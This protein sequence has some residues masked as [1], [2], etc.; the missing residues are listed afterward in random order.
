MQGNDVE[1]MSIDGIGFRGDL[2]DQW[3]DPEGLDLEVI[4]PPTEPTPRL[5]FPPEA[6]LRRT[7]LPS[8]IDLSSRPD[9]GDPGA[10]CQRHRL[11]I[12]VRSPAV[13]GLSLAVGS[14][15]PNRRRRPGGR[16]V[17]KNDYERRL[18]ARFERR[19]RRHRGIRKF[20]C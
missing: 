18:T 10:E 19:R 8:E 5:G 14:A 2:I 16:T 15:W 13:C 6:S 3:S 11:E 9:D 12:P 20:A 1:A 7:R 4:V 17:I